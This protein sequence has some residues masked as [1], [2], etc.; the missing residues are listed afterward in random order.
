MKPIRLLT[1]PKAK[2]GEQIV[3]MEGDEGGMHRRLF[4]ACDLFLEADT[5]SERY[6]VKE[7]AREFAERFVAQMNRGNT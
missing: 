6:R 3:A 1:F 5:W 4:D 2:Y 7:M